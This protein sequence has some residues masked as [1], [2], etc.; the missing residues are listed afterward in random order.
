MYYLDFSM[1]V[2]PPSGVGEENFGQG[3]ANK[4]IRGI[5]RITTKVKETKQKKKKSI[6]QEEKLMT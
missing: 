5:T 3:D 6:I 1:T 2:F 4:W